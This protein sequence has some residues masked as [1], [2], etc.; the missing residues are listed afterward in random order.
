[1]QSTIDKIQA[2]D[3]VEVISR[4]LDLKKKGVNYTACC[5]FHNEK[6]PSF[7]VST[8]KNIFKCFGCGKGGNAISFVMEHEGLNFIEAC[9]VIAKNHNIDFEVKERTPEELEQQK[10]KEALY[11]VNSLAAEYYH[12]NLYEKEN[13]LALEYVKSRW[14][15]ESI[16][17]FKIGYAS[18][19]WDGLI[20]YAKESGLK[21]D[22][23]HQAGLIKEKKQG[24]FYDVFRGRI[25]FPFFDKYSRIIG[26]TGREQTGNKEAAKYMNT[27]ET[28]IYKKKSFLYG[29]HAAANEIRKKDRAYLVE[30][31]PDVIRLHELEINNTVC[32]GGT[33][34]TAEHIQQLKSMCKSIVIIGDNDPAG[35]RAVENSGK[36]IIKEGLFC[37][38]L[39]FP[40][41]EDK[42]GKIIKQD[43]DS[44]FTNKTREQ[45]K[46]YRDEHTT[47]FI[48]YL[49]QIRKEKAKNASFKQKLVADL[50]DLVFSLPEDVHTFYIDELG[51]FIQ[52]KKALE[53][54]L[55][56]LNKER[57]KDEVT[58]YIPKH[59]KLKEFEEMGFYV[60]ENRYFFRGKGG[61]TLQGSNFVLEPLFHV[62]EIHNAKRLFLIKNHYGIEKF[63]ELDQADLIGLAKFRL[64]IESI[65]NF[66]WEAGEA[67]LIKLKKA[68]Y[69]LT[70]T[71]TMVKQMGYQP[72]G[73]FAWCNGIYN[74]EYTKTD[75]LGIV[76]HGE[77]H[78]YIPSSSEIYEN[79]AGLFEAE[80]KFIYRTGTVT[81]KEYTQRLEIVFG[82]NARIAFC[83]LIASL[84]RDLIVN[85]YRFF[86]ILNL[87]GLKGSGK[88]ELGESLLHFFGPEQK[89]INLPNSTEPATADYISQSRNAVALLDEYKNNF[90]PSKIE[91]LK[92]LWKAIGRSRMNM[93]KDKKKETTAV[94][95]G[96]ILCGQEMPT[97]DIALFSR[98]IYLTFYKTEF[99]AEEKKAFEELKNI[100]RRGLGHLTHEILSHREHFEDNYKEA[101]EKAGEDLREALGEEIVE[102][103]IYRNWLI[104][105]GTFLTL[106][107]RLETAYNYPELI[108]T[109]KDQILQQNKE[110]KGSNE[111]SVF[112]NMVQYLAADGLIHNE[113]DFKIKEVDRLNTDLLE[114]IEFKKLTNVLFIQHSR[115]IPLYRKYGR[116]MGEN[117]LPAESIDYYLRNDKRFLG[118]KKSE[119]FI[120]ADPKTGQPEIKEGS[121]TP[122]K[123]VTTAYCFLYDPLN[124]SLKDVDTEEDK[125]F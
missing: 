110:T 39:V 117:I 111:I 93:D 97:A 56:K 76:K 33:S 35:L 41:E 113:V 30:G 63:I 121:N 16:Q 3:I 20:N 21:T 31:N 15:K 61:K 19:S 50:T 70:L 37:E 98:L 74:G 73:F 69:K 109:A 78:F 120:K 66:I 85:E 77:Q 90:E 44:F 17:F 100:E 79:E 96:I 80:K 32:T 6:T 88:T 108:T 14:S 92:G 22:Y 45:F 29:I 49:A 23:L 101:F 40:D 123:K 115:I 59:V 104:V 13:K 7:S 118:K 5:P 64:R 91:F 87:F 11:K 114:N 116:Q 8:S 67:E 107:D 58:E 62:E 12:K 28:I 55:N 122:T 57:N 106:K 71:C 65:G 84:Y 81:L 89:G 9:R 48:I 60:D 54:R 119:K 46:E 94:D 86:P 99:T 95:T 36:K 27:P 34:L 125:P 68:L 53:D 102:D 112:W 52:P 72:G 124:I 25:I 26:F 10:Q 105:L 51:K 18:D 82:N 42:E 75:N 47:D 1:M 103:R 2:L 24:G 4:Y 38:V 83:Y 43:P